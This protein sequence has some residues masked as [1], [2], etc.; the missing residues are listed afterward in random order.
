MWSLV[1]HSVFPSSFPLLSDLFSMEGG[2]GCSG[3]SSSMEIWAS[4]LLNWPR[5]DVVNVSV[6]VRNLC[7]TE[8]ILIVGKN[9]SP[10]SLRVPNSKTQLLMI[11]LGIYKNNHLLLWLWLAFSHVMGWVVIKIWLDEK[12]PCLVL[13]WSWSHSAL[14]PSVVHR[15]QVKSCCKFQGMQSF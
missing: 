14:F 9:P 10:Q 6:C 2:A 5:Q 13:Q 4:Y 1:Y 8:G 7:I 12:F 11:Q 3:W 15:E